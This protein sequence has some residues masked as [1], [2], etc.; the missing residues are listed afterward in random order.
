[1]RTPLFRVAL[2]AAGCVAAAGVA[3]GV[4]VERD[5]V[6]A[7][8]AGESLTGDVYRPERAGRRPGVLLVHGGGWAFGDKAQMSHLGRLLART[9]FT[10]MSV[11]YRLAPRHTFPAQCED[12][13]AAVAWMRSGGSEYGVRGDWVAAYGYSAGAHLALL[14]GLSAGQEGAALESAAEVEAIVAGGA[15]CDLHLPPLDASVFS[16]WL[17]ASRREAPEIYRQAS[18]GTFARAD[19]PPT[20]FFHGESDRLVPIASSRR[21]FT[22]LVE[23]GAPVEFVAVP[24]A[25]HIATFAHER[26][27]RQAVAFLKQQAVDDLGA[28]AF[29]AGD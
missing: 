17:G 12:V 1:M 27:A 2:V 8:A 3:P 11:N 16:Y 6:F 21:L 10:A 5:V 9:G 4:E 28:E 22:K 18:P 23:L 19:A 7:T 13:A 20:L 25:G 15:P 26:A 14:V 29:A 24:K